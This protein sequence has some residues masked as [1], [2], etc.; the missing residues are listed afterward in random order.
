MGQTRK[1]LPHA[2]RVGGFI[3]LLSHHPFHHLPSEVT[4]RPGPTGVPPNC[5]ASLTPPD[6]L[7]SLLLR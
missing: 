6:H 5:I 4:A 7:A 3:P 2:D 1:P